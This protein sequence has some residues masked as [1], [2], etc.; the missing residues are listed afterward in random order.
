MSLQPVNLNLLPLLRALIKYRS[1]TQAARSIG[2]SQSAASQGLA[3]LRVQVNDP[4]LVRIGG[5][6]QLTPL[7][8]T[9]TSRV[10]RVSAELD[11]LFLP[12]R[13]DPATSE[14][15]FVI[16]ANDYMV[17][18]LGKTIIE[19]QRA[20]AP[21][22]K[23]HFIEIGTDMIERM[24]AQEIDFAL[25]PRFAVRDL[26]VAPLRYRMLFAD[27]AGVVMD[28][29]HPLA[30]RSV[31]SEADLAPFDC[32]AFHVEALERI[33]TKH[34]KAPPEVAPFWETMRKVTVRTNHFTLVPALLENT[35]LITLLPYDIGVELS[36][37][38][39]ITVRRLSFGPRR[40][41]HGLAWSPVFDAD[42]GHSWFRAQIE[43]RVKAQRRLRVEESIDRQV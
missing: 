1:V 4:L 28:C 40:I 10:E 29:A 36:K 15:T 38:W 12:S 35:D 14:R 13:F 37:I 16:A 3:R 25:L 30:S 2:I 5:R 7:A 42:P 23:I 43:Q 18:L 24:A 41:E 27:Q 21:G 11:D 9:L 8:R 31:V 33:P 32:I 34:W 26:T 19:L 20:E 6:M 39:P 22:I 17:Y